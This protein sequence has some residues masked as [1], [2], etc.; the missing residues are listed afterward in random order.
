MALSIPLLPPPAHRPSSPAAARTCLTRSGMCLI[1]FYVD[2]SC[3]KARETQP[4][5]SCGHSTDNAQVTPRSQGQHGAHPTRRCLM[6]VKTRRKPHNEL[7]CSLQCHRASL[8][9]CAHP[10]EAERGS[11]FLVHLQQVA[12]RHMG[13]VGN[14]DWV[15]V[16][17]NYTMLVAPCLA[18]QHSPQ[19]LG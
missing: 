12:P 13:E 5:G 9:C 6:V 7:S 1:P 15:T 18:S 2:I 14:M 10:E 17:R 11:L 3:S 19:T 8:S 16:T 4:R